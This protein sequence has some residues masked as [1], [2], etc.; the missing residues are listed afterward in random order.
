MHVRIENM[1]SIW[2]LYV[3]FFMLTFLNTD[4]QRAKAAEGYWIVRKKLLN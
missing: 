4:E 2:I 1:K 3:T